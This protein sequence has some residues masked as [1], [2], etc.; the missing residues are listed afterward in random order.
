VFNVQLDNTVICTFVSSAKEED[1]RSGQFFCQSCC[2]AI[3][4]CVILELEQL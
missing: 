3:C 2:H 4:V 1:L